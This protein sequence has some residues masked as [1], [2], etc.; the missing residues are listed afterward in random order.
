MLALHC[1]NYMKARLGTKG[2]R[3]NINHMFFSFL[4]VSLKLPYISF[5]QMH[6]NED[7]KSY[8]LAMN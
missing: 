6:K 2:K 4:L 7:T 3:T 8:F 1:A 5:G